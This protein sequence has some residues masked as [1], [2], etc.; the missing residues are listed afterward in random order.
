ARSRSLKILLEYRDKDNAWHRVNLGS[1]FLLSPDGLFVTAYHVMKHCLAAQRETD[2]LSVRIDCS[3]ARP[4][5]RYV[6]V[7]ENREFPVE[8]IS[9]LKEADSTKGK[10][11]HTP[12]E[13]IKQRDFVIGK[14]KT[15][16]AH[17]FSFWR[18]RDFDQA[19]VDV[20]N[21]NADFSLTPL[22]PPKRVFIAGFPN[23][24]DFVISEGFLNLTEKNRRGYFAADL[25]VYTRSYLESQGVATDTKW[26]MRVD[27]HMSGGAVVDSSGY[28][29]GLVVNGNH[30]TAGILS[31]EN[32]LATFFSRAGGSEARPAVLLNPTDTPLFLKQKA[33][34]DPGANQDSSP[35]LLSRGATPHLS[36][37]T[38]PSSSNSRLSRSAGAVR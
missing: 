35:T 19:S 1:G 32:I 9:H 38:D 12:D 22:M 36:V 16:A 10:E 29:V 30:N 33:L 37:A 7:N 34:H 5:V 2:G 20:N 27:N 14:V 6:A 25:K 26:G 15:E 17:T 31:I 8:I 4:D 23:D 21:P 28:V 13:I 24:H 3:T 18:L 11:K